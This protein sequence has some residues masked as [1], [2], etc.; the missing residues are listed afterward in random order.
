MS[1]IVGSAR[2]FP[3]LP[4]PLQNSLVAIQLTITDEKRAY[5]HLALKGETRVNCSWTKLDSWTDRR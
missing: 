1:D 4:Q 5:R 2:S 3:G